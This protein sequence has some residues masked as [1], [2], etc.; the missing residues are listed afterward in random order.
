MP[1]DTAAGMWCRSPIDASI[2]LSGL[3]AIANFVGPN[4]GQQFRQAI[5]NA[6]GGTASIAPTLAADTAAIGVDL[7]GA[8]AAA[9][10][11]DAALRTL[12]SRA[13]DRINFADYTDADP[14]GNNGNS[15]LIDQAL[16]DA[17]AEQGTRVPGR[18][19]G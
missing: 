6:P 13:T 16:T 2:V 17:R 15:N 10:I 11:A 5:N 19:L 4:S 18:S 14:A 7:G 8:V 3:S 9:S 12:A 1:V